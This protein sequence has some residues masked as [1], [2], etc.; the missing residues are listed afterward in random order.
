MPTRSKAC[1][2]GCSLARMLGSNPAE[3]YA[4]SSLVV[5]VCCVV[6]GLCEELINRLG[7]SY[8]LCLSECDLY[9]DDVLTN[10]GGD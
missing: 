8:Q 1:V 3:R 7:N 2:C 5:A 4:Y 10:R 6:S 9:N